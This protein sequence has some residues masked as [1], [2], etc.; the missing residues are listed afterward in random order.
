MVVYDVVGCGA[1]GGRAKLHGR[2]TVFVVGV[3]TWWPLWVML[4]YGG[5]C[6][7]WEVVVVCMGDVVM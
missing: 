6:G 4:G 5:A 1:G 2:E 7:P 3:V